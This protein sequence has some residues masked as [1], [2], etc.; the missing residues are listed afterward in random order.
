MEV[1][2]LFEQLELTESRLSEVESERDEALENLAIAE[3]NVQQAAEF[4]SQ[5]IEQVN[6]LE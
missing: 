6:K 4:G 1:D 5:L 2:R 3:D